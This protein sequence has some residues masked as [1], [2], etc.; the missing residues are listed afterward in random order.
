MKNKIIIPA[1]FAL[2]LF[3]LIECC[4]LFTSPTVVSVSPGNDQEVGTNFSITIVFSKSMHKDTV[5]NAFA[6]YCL[7]SSGNSSSPGAL[8]EGS[9]S[10]DSDTT[11][12]F[13]PFQDQLVYPSQYSIQIG[14]TAADSDGNSLGNT[15]YS[16]FKIM[17]N[18]IYPTIVATYPTNGAINVRIQTNITIQFSM[19]MDQGST[20]SAFSLNPSI[21]GNLSL[22][23]NILLF[24]PS[25]PLSNGCYYNVNVANTAQGTNGVK[26][27]NSYVF[28]F[29]AGNGLT[30]PAVTGIYTNLNSAPLTNYQSGIEKT[31][32]N[33]FIL[34]NI[35][36]DRDSV[37]NNLS[38]TPSATYYINW[39]SG[40]TAALYFTTPLIPSTNYTISLSA[41][42]K[43]TS[44]SLLQNNFLFNFYTDGLNS[45]LP[46][47]NDIVAETTGGF[48]DMTNTNII[49]LI[50]IT[51]NTLCIDVSFSG[52]ANINL[53]SLYTNSSITFLYGSGDISQS[54]K[55]YTI[56]MT[57][58]NKFT[59]TIT[60]LC[61]SNYYKFSMTGGANGI[62]DVLQNPLSGSWN[63]YF[64][65]TNTN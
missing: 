58:P 33:F 38:I 50:P 22:K 47:V 57:G 60:S 52:P 64:S 6:L 25:T 14:N 23:S 51:A 16:R 24:Q 32:T 30:L 17:G 3:G 19:P 27:Q 1:L 10:W 37:Y 29:L 4:S 46:F 26:L 39:I 65:I 5:Q 56:N 49:Y 59:Y 9:F 61:L 43:S 12:V 20:I 31:N 45:T 15:Y 21:A 42:T 62:Q 48:V 18:A 54:G 44:G 8:I 40:N 53:L 35:P 55:I 2:F 36:M 28:Y 7:G 41:G 13:S 11:L 63:I 34:F